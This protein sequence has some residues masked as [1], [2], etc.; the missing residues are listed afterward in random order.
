MT[1]I[2]LIITYISVFVSFVNS[3]LPTTSTAR[4]IRTTPGP[5]LDQPH[6]L[7]ATRVE[8][9]CSRNDPH[10]GL[11]FLGLNHR[12]EKPVARAN[13]EPKNEEII[14]TDEELEKTLKQEEKYA[15]TSEKLSNAPQQSSNRYKMRYELEKI[16]DKIRE[17]RR[18]VHI[19]L[20]NEKDFDSRPKTEGMKLLER[21]WNRLKEVSDRIWG[22]ETR[23]Y[24]SHKDLE[25]TRKSNSRKDLKEFKRVSKVNTPD[26]KKETKDSR[27]KSNQRISKTDQDELEEGLAA[28]EKEW[29]RQNKERDTYQQWAAE[30]MDRR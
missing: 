4:T 5:D 21:I 13:S 8:E 26:M 22:K 18:R 29:V 16:F 19:D 28:I 1:H 6:Y 3:L 14:L 12:T 17:V 30:E 10:R 2:Y 27:R 20:L 9:P 25:E 15:K 7:P 23:K 24:N 11:D